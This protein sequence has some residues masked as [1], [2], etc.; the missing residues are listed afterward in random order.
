[1]EDSGVEVKSSETEERNIYVPSLDL[2]TIFV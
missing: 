1:M 2:I